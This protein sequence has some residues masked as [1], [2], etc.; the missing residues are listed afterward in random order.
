[1][2]ADPLA[3]S[4]LQTCTLS[5]W[6]TDQ[7]IYLV[8]GERYEKLGLKLSAGSQYY[9]TSRLWFWACWNPQTCMH[10]SIRGC[11]HTER[12]WGVFGL[13]CTGT[14]LLLP[15][16]SSLFPI[17]PRTQL[18]FLFLLLPLFSFFYPYFLWWGLMAENSFSTQHLHGGVPSSL[19]L[20]PLLLTSLPIFHSL[21]TPLSPAFLFPSPYIPFTDHPKFSFVF[22]LHQGSL[23]T[24]ALFVL[25][26]LS[27]PKPPRKEPNN[28][29]VDE[30]NHKP[31]CPTHPSEP[32][33][34]SSNG[35]SRTRNET[36][37][38]FLYFH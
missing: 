28:S 30:D 1:M 20:P 8:P 4:V 9:F 34:L 25:L 11:E 37:V 32:Q 19:T 2:N 21:A 17:T 23:H 18:L 27:S 3:A 13:V 22:D 15:L 16:C 10:L 36:T 31:K 5:E 26:V 14:Q 29:T 12:L 7:F 33:L 35:G 6:V 24:L 38:D